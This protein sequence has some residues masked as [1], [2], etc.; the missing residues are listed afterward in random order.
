MKYLL[1]ISCLLLMHFSML[2][3]QNSI[4]E[5]DCPDSTDVEMISIL[6]WNV[7]MLPPPFFRTQQVPRCKA[8]IEFLNNSSY[9]VLVLQEVFYERVRQ[10]LINGLGGCYPYHYGPCGTD[11]FLRQDGG[12]MIFS[13]YPIETSQQIA[14]RD[15]C[16]GG[17]CLSDK[18][19]LLAEVRKNRKKIQIVGTHLQSMDD[20]VAQGIRVRQYEKI[21]HFLLR[22]FQKHGVP[23][24][25]VGDL[26]TCKVTQKPFYKRMLDIFD[27][28]DSHKSK[29]EEFTYDGDSNE[30]VKKAYPKYRRFFDY[31]LF[32]RNPE[33]HFK[34]RD[35]VVRLFRK[36]GI[37]PNHN[38]ELS[39]HFA[40]EAIIEWE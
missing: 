39:D 6:S 18:G 38:L 8:I 23:Q 5:A 40:V 11:K 29:K 1:S 13:K 33:K 37:D 21:K 30:I 22:P 35:F 25:I 17:D 34:V 19:A 7:Y 27:A 16:K 3:G 26:N 32:R 2:S 14:F 4:T 10:K 28:E 24:V 9:E 15:K 12:V 20:T 31:V 36:R